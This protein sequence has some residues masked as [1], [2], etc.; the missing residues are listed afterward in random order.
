LSW[1][2]FLANELILLDTL[3]IEKSS[4]SHESFQLFDLLQENVASVDSIVIILEFLKAEIKSLDKI[5][6]N[7]SW[8]WLENFFERAISKT[9]LFPLN[10]HNIMRALASSS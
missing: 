9:L 3:I 2:Y 10:F 4:S 8:F 1:G 5:L 6:D 7:F